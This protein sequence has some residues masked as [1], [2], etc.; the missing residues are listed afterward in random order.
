MYTDDPLRP[1]VPWWE[2]RDPTNAFSSKEERDMARARH[3]TSECSAVEDRQRSLHELNLWNAT[4]YT[5]RKLT[6]FNW[7]WNEPTDTDLVPCNLITEN[8]VLSIGD[9]MLSRAATSPTRVVPTP[10]GADFTTYRLVKKLDKWLQ[11]IWR[12]KSI[13]DLHLQLF[14]DAYISGFGCLRVDWDPEKEDLCIERVFFDNVVVDNRECAN[15]QFP[16]T[17]RIRQVV[18]KEQVEER[19]NKRLDPEDA[20]S[21]NYSTYRM[22][23]DGWVPVTEGWRM[24]GPNGKGGRHMVSSCGVTLVDEEWVDSEPPLI[25]FH[26]SR[27][28]SGFHRAGG[29][30][31]VVPYQ[32]RLNE[33]NEVI[34]DAQD[35]MA[36]PRILVHTGSNVDVNAIDNVVGRIIK[37]TGIK[38]EALVWDAVSGELLQERDRLVASCFEFFGISQMSGQASLPEGVRLDSSAAVRE[39]TTQ[40]DQRHLDLWRRFEATRVQTAK[41][42]IRVMTRVGGNLKTSWGHPNRPGGDEIEW[43]EV[44]GIADDSYTWSLEAASLN[45]QSPGARMDTLNTWI[46][47]GYITPERASILSGNPDL[48][49]IQELE[50]ASQDDIK[51]VAE[52]LEA[53]EY[54]APDPTQNLVYGLWAITQNLARL[55]NFKKNTEVELAKEAHIRWIRQCLAIQQGPIDAPV[56]PAEQPIDPMTG[57]PLPMMGMSSAPP[58]MPQLPVDP[59]LGVGAMAPMGQMLQGSPGSGF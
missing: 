41:T 31:Q 53:G 1:V 4:L 20:G 26:W 7:G 34:R 44:E 13:E 12:D 5:N 21:R 8:L 56:P 3:L 40:A 52:L 39:F 57:A 10:R 36:R 51:R 33:I 19:Y 35:L 58:Q 46:A 9:A 59:G 43:K 17:Y 16:R 42:M 23:G 25:F 29:V 38:P 11:G 2:A 32:I 47:Q 27:T 24:P 48:E 30:E 18:P 14:L 15:T 45:T 6:G 49:G 55:R 54:E 37:Y 50:T 22:M 28:A